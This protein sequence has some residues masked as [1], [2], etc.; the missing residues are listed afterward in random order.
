M[1]AGPYAGI[2]VEG[3]EAHALELRPSSGSQM[4]TPEPQS[5]QKTF[6]KPPSGHQV[7]SRSSPLTIRIDPGGKRPVAP[8]PEPVRCWQRVQWQ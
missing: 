3:P 8:P 5:P 7:R 2:A 6:P 1:Q 4:K